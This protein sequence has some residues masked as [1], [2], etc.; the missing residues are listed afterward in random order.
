MN[1]D[2]A[3][4][5]L[6]GLAGATLY[7]SAHHASF[8]LARRSET[9]H[10]WVALWGGAALLQQLGR[11][12]HY[13]ASTEAG[14]VW[15][16]KL[17][18]AAV[19]LCGVV[20][21]YVL[22]AFCGEHG[23]SRFL[24]LAMPMHALL[25]WLCLG[26][27]VLFGSVAQPYTDAAGRS[28]LWVDAGP[29][30]ALFS[31]WGLVLL[32]Y[33]IRLMSRNPLSSTE[34]VVLAIT[35]F[36]YVVLGLS[37]T[38]VAAGIIEQV[39]MFD[40]SFAIVVFGFA[41]IATHRFE[42]L[43]SGLE[44]EVAARTEQLETA[45]G[46]VR[47]AAEAKERFF[48][49]ISHEIRTPLHG[50]QATTQLLSEGAQDDEQARLAGIA[51]R[52]TGELRRLVDDLLDTSA[53]RAGQLAFH[54]N[55]VD[56]KSLAS[57][58]VLDWRARAQQEGVLLS[59]LAPEAVAPVLADDLRLRQVLSNLISNGLKFTPKGAVTVG[60]D[61]HPDGWR[62]SVTDNGPGLAPE[63]R[64]AVFD[65]FHQEPDVRGGTGLGLTIARHLVQGMGGQL[66]VD[67]ELGAGCSFWFVLPACPA[68]ALEQSIPM[69]ASGSGVV[70]VVDDNPINR[71]VARLALRRLGVTVEEAPDG[72]AAV[73]RALRG[74]VDLIFMDLQMPGLDG[75]GATQRIRD[76]RS[77]VSQV[78]IVAMTASTDPA[79]HL[80]CREAGMV[81]V[82]PKPLDLAQLRRVVTRYVDLT[83]RR[84]QD[85]EADDLVPMFLVDATD[86]VNHPGLRGDR[87]R[88]KEVG[89]A[90]RGGASSLGLAPIV[91][92]CHA[93]E[94]DPGPETLQ[95]LR[96]GLDDLR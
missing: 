45:L 35:A 27:D 58:L 3:T 4:A 39:L 11:L 48:A 37:D 83:G 87:A 72:F 20:A 81:E 84:P 88:L 8:W 54:I 6:L 12:A 40:Y 96:D 14:A 49:S 62:F 85:E 59:L 43:H 50:L 95:A 64:R 86:R 31:V 73:A 1:L 32:A 82:L 38:L 80:R 79:E 68:A 94:S 7:L 61:E 46:E 67:S 28:F 21:P 16:L 30:V 44:V 22:R 53:L 76:A 65:A 69:P 33:G 55:P 89:H 75:P 10:G 24:T 70:L 71:E 13:G 56:G 23:P 78:P 26:T 51:V 74:G 42:R 92:L 9:L 41:W 25:L 90:V 17:S 52:S 18:M 2:P 34:R 5:V 66:S 91:A 36:I 19:I 47:N 77:E 60:V 29:G 93:L 63:A 15:A 57:E